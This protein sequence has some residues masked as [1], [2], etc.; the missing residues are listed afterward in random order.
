MRVAKNRIIDYTNKKSFVE[1]RILKTHDFWY[2]LPEELIAQTPLQ[3]RDSSRLLVMNRNSG[4]V[5]HRHFY[6]EP[7]HRHDR[8]RTAV[9]SFKR[10]GRFWRGLF[11]RGCGNIGYDVYFFKDCRSLIGRIAKNAIVLAIMDGVG[12][13]EEKVN[14]TLYKMKESN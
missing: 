12:Y 6:D 7:G 10:T 11:C 8:R 13:T 1:D 5:S 3:K 2:D 4:E 14:V 9:G